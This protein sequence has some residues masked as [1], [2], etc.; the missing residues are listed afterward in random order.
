[1][2]PTHVLS[3]EVDTVKETSC[4][5][6]RGGLRLSNDDSIPSDAGSPQCICAAMFD[7]KRDLIRRVNLRGGLAV[8]ETTGPKQVMGRFQPG[9]S[10]NPRG[11]PPGA[12]NKA[13]RAAEALLDGEAETLNGAASRPCWAAIQ[14]PCGFALNGYCRRAEIDR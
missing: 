8:T 13:T 12:R 3:G 6:S 2:R 4:P 9:Q 14:P 10:G 5:L 7:L 11:R 1:M